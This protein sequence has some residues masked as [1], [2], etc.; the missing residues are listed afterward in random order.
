MAIKWRGRANSKQAI[1]YFVTEK[2]STN[3]SHDKFHGKR[4]LAYAVYL[5]LFFHFSDTV[6]P[7]KCQMQT[8]RIIIFIQQLPQSRK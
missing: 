2:T 5:S 4:W 6:F 8:T 3:D 1:H 7:K